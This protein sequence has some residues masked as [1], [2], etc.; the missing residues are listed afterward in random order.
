MDI[1]KLLAQDCYVFDKWQFP[2]HEYNY[3]MAKV[4][5][6]YSDKNTH[7]SF[8]EFA[9]FCVDMFWCGCKYRMKNMESRIED[10]FISL[11]CAYKV[12]IDA[13]QYALN[14]NLISHQAKQESY[15]FLVDM[16]KLAF[17]KGVDYANSQWRGAVFDIDGTDDT[18]K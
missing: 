7:C 9:N 3:H 1:K 13:L 14:K 8:N 11:E 12:F 16:G 4:L 18:I 2:Q 6:K 17:N 10:G 5:E 15:K